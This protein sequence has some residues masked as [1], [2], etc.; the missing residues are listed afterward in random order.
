MAMAILVAGGAGI[1]ALQQATTEGN[2][3]ARE[4][5]TATTIARTWVERLKRDTV[6]WTTGGAG[7]PSA[8]LTRTLYL[9][10]VPA[11]GTTS[12]WTTPVP[13]DLAVES[14]AFDYF[15]NDTLPTAAGVTYC[16]QDRLQ[17]VSPG[18]T[19]RADVRVWWPR[20]SRVGGNAR[21]PNCGV[22]S[23]TAIGNS[24]SVRSVTTSVLLHFTRRQ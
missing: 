4:M 16:A 8:D 15:G 13:P 22:G 9:L 11:A 23:E 5:T 14:Y 2:L 3:E 17:W 21:F 20:N 10:A 7:V 12:T 24:N 1:L 18:R 6:L 19:I